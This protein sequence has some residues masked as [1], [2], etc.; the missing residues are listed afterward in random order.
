MLFSIQIS[1][2]EIFLM[3]VFFFYMYRFRNAIPGL[4]RFILF[5]VMPTF[6]VKDI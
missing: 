3:R 1:D 4:N 2:I 5:Q 6:L